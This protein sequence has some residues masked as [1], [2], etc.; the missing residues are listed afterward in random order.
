MKFHLGEMIFFQLG[1]WPISF[2]CL[3][4]IPR[5]E[6]HCGCY[7]IAV[8]LTDEISFGKMLC[9]HYPKIKSYENKH[10]RKCKGN[11]LFELLLR[12]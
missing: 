5:N 9:K 7:S 2:N 11:T 6:F 8:I 3:D 4:D 1:V 10:L 12:N